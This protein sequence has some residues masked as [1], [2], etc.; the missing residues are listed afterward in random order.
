MP[1]CGRSCSASAASPLIALDIVG[2]TIAIY[3]ALVLRDIY[4]GNTVFWGYSGEALPDYLPF[5][6]LVTMLVFSQARLYATRERRPGFG[7]IVSSIFSSR[8]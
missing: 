6:A 4:Y 5:A 1:S 3:A 7:R 8:C 2:L